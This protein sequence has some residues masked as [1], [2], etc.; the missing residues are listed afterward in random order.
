MEDTMSS[1]S[2]IEIVRDVLERGFG[3]GDLSVVDEYVAADFVEHQAGVEGR[4]PE[5]VKRTIRGLHES[6]SDM[7]LVVKDIVAVGDNVW[8]RVRASAVNTKPIMG[9]PAT[10][11]SFEIDIIDVMRLREG[12]LVEHWGVADRLAMLQQLGLVPR[13]EARAA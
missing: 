4:G 10:G 7:R 6:F 2:N 8:A 13:P 5:A 11:R 3:G 12:K 9:R 1:Q